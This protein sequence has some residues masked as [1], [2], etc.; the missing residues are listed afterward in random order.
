[1]AIKSYLAHP[2]K[3]QKDK[4]INE[5][6]ALKNC[7]IIPAENKEVIILITETE[8]D[9]EDKM[10]KEKIETFNSLKL[11]ALVSGFNSPKNN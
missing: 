1:M 4:L 9:N 10:L 8:N 5:L 11:L 3:G 6:S 7:E 2:N